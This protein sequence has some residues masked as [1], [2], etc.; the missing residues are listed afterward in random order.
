MYRVNLESGNGV[1]RFR[2]LWPHKRSESAH[3]PH[4]S[5]TSDFMKW[6]WICVSPCLCPWEW[7]CHAWKA[8]L[9]LEPSV[10]PCTSHSGFILYSVTCLWLL[11]LNNFTNCSYLD[12]T[13]VNSLGKSHGLQW[14]WYSCLCFSCIEP[15]LYFHCLKSQITK[16]VFPAGT[17]IS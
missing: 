14:K 11:V 1:P 17:V 5:L 2:L 3:S 16:L 6:L 12:W 13:S 7:V 10:T 4:F 9:P 8:E 15:T